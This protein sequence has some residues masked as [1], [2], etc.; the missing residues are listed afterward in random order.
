MI[1]L[2]LWMVQDPWYDTCNKPTVKEECCN[3][4]IY[5][6]NKCLFDFKYL[7]L[8]VWVTVFCSFT[9]SVPYLGMTHWGFDHESGDITNITSDLTYRSVSTPVLIKDLILLS[10][11]S[12]FSLFICL[13]TI[14]WHNCWQCFYSQYPRISS[15][16]DYDKPLVT[17]FP[18]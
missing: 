4:P 14:G 16:I 12:L 15:F 6:K 17:L 10:V 11:L 13:F 18:Y 1:K 2:Y 7:Q 5:N 8:Y 9:V 3:T